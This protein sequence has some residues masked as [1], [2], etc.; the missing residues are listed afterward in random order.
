MVK[1]YSPLI[2]CLVY[3]LLFSS[4]GN[5]KCTDVNNKFAGEVSGAITGKV[6][7]HGIIRYNPPPLKI[8]LFR[9]TFSLQTVPEYASWV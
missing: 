6:N 8:L 7:G 5:S 9:V 3:C 4:C 1:I 2:T